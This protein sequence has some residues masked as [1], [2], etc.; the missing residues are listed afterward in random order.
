MTRIGGAGP[1][2]GGTTWA[3]GS[4]AIASVIVALLPMGFLAAWLV[5]RRARSA[6]GW[7]AAAPA[8]TWCAGVTG[9]PGLTSLPSH[10]P[11]VI[12]GSPGFPLLGGV[13]RVL[14]AVMLVLVTTAR[15]T[16]LAV[17]GALVP[18][19]VPVGAGLRGAA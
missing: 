4:A 11:I 19:A 18:S 7:T 17:D 1:E 13:E 6:P 5:A 3:G 10:V 8:L 16:R 15:A 2:P 9:L 14:Y 12:G